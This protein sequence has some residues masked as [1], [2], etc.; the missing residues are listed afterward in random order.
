MTKIIR[1][2]STHYFITKIPNKREL[3]Q[4][5]HSSDVYFVDFINLYKIC[6]EKPY[7]SLV[8]IDTTLASGNHLR[9]RKN[10][11]ERI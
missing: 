10:L 2:N 7:S 4:M 9:F 11:S 6:I 8:T 3:Q 1:I 5:Q